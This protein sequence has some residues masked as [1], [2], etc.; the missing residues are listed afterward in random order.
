VASGGFANGRRRLASIALLAL[1][2]AG[3]LGFGAHWYRELRHRE[4]TDDAFVEASLA[5]ISARVGGTVIEV[6]V[7]E[8]QPVRAG[9]L[10][11]R[12]DPTDFE[13]GVARARAN[14]EEARNRLAAARAAADGAEAERRAAV[15]ELERARGEARRVEG[16]RERGAT[17]DQLVENAVAARDAAEARVLA[18]E[19]RVLAERAVLGNEA[20]LR[21][22][23][24]ALREAELALSYTTLVA[25]HAGTVGR[26]SVQQGENVAA[27]RPLLALARDEA[28]WVVANFKETQIGRMQVGDRAEVEIDAFPGHACRGHVESL[29]PA[30]GAKYALIPPDNATGNFTKVVQ[31]VPVR[32]ALDACD[33]NGNGGNPLDPKRLAMGLSALVSV[34]VGD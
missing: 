15:I 6:A 31:R 18:L 30:T 17:S 25:P 4:R 21:Q 29:S 23:E 2:C 8:N 20:P 24:A 28:S 9:D 3:A 10:L 19:Q 32:V 13:V 26:K 27:G 14:L 7:E 33:E 11:V 22:A 16:L 12:L 34:R 1:L 5:L